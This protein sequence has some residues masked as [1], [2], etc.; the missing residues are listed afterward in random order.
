MSMER[1]Q[2]ALT[3][4][5]A[6]EIQPDIRKIRVATTEKECWSLAT[7]QTP[8]SSSLISEKGIY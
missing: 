5:A 4:F 7:D 8:I 2:E 6:R 3:M 1:Q